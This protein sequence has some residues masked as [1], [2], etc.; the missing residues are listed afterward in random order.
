[1]ISYLLHHTQL[2]HHAKLPKPDL[3]T[4]GDMRLAI[5]GNH[6]WLTS[7]SKTNLQISFESGVKELG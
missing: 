5:L 6:E 7:I 2:M 4:C 1:M 3:G